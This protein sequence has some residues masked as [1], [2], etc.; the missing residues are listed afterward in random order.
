MTESI[1][2]TCVSNLQNDDKQTDTSDLMQ[3]ISDKNEALNSDLG[4]GVDKFYLLFAVSSVINMLYNSES[5]L[6]HHIHQN[7]NIPFY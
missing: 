6:F 3:C 5:L 2:A 4:A 7:F 1:Y